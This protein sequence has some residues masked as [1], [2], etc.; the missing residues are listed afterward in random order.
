MGD[1]TIGQHRRRSSVK[2]GYPKDLS[3]R[4]PG[5]KGQ[6]SS[7]SRPGRFSRERRSHEV[8]LGAND[9]VDSDF[10]T[11]DDVELK[12]IES[13]YDHHDEDDEETGLTQRERRR[14]RRIK[15]HNG[16]LDARIVKKSKMATVESSLTD[17]SVLR[18]S[19][20]NV[21]LIGCW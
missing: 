13:D 21:S 3:I 20:T 8:H 17:Q 5:R 6:K 9:E 7:S 18:R 4:E 11:S 12:D 1:P 10:S 16:R 2:G 19:L 14:N 15:R